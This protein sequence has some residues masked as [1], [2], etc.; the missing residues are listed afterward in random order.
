MP[1][2]RSRIVEAIAILLLSRPMRAA[3]IAQLLGYPVNYVTSYLS[4]WKV[5]GLFDYEHGFWKLTPEGEKFARNILARETSEKT[6]QYAALAKTIL[7]GSEQV[8]RTINDKNEFQRYSPPSRIQQ[9]TADLT[10]TVNSKR[11]DTVAICVEALLETIELEEE[12]KEV[13]EYMLLHY[14]KW[15]STYTY[16]ENLEDSLQ[17]DRVWLLRIL[18][19]LQSKGLV[20]IYMDRRLGTRIGLSKKVKEYL[21]QCESSAP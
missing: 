11:Q 19:S 8:R 17:A 15:G 13:M 9:F 6:A 12:E 2:P 21:K 1:R 10:N 16:I 18:R 4:Y 3:E 7:A 14:A 5:R 20:Y